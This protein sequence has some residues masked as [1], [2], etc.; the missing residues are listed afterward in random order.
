MFPELPLPSSDG[1]IVVDCRQH[2]APT[3]NA[4][5]S[6][7]HAAHVASSARRLCP[8]SAAPSPRVSACERRPGA[9]SYP[10]S[11]FRPVVRA[12]GVVVWRA[13]CVIAWARSKRGRMSR[14]RTTWQGCQCPASPHPWHVA[15]LR[16]SFPAQKDSTRRNLNICHLPR[17]TCHV[18]HRASTLPGANRRH[19]RGGRCRAGGGGGGAPGDAIGRPLAPSHVL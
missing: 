18:A 6:V 17:S 16:Y 10:S 3:H 2:T 11:R 15:D 5:G 14:P 12:A 19:L 7:A 13:E 9:G 1:V 8:P 4:R